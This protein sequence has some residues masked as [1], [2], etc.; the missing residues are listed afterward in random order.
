MLQYIP[1]NIKETNLLFGYIKYGSSELD[2]PGRFNYK[3]YL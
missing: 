3:Q 2:V 1:E